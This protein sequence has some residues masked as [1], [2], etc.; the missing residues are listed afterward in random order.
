VRVTWDPQKA[1]ANLQKHRT[2]FEEAATVLGDPLA[3][4]HDDPG[5]SVLERRE[6]IVGHSLRGR[7]LVVSFSE[8][9]GVVR[10]ISAR[11]ATKAERY[12]YEEGQS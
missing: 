6:I 4:I 11:P 7:L 2:S 3:R 5:H 1:A 10:L 8:R 9:E 12:D